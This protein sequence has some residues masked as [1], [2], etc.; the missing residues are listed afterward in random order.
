M[1][2]CAASE[3]AITK[4]YATPLAFES[5]LK[6]Y[7]KDCVRQDGGTVNAVMRGF[8]FQRLTARVFSADPDRWLLKGGQALLVRYPSGARLSS[9]IDFQHLDDDLD[10]ALAA[11]RAAAATDLGDHLSFVPSSSSTHGVQDGGVRQG[12]DV[13][14]GINRR[15]SVSVDLVVRRNITAPPQV[16]SLHP[17]PGVP[18]PTD[19]PKVRL[20]PVVDHI[21]DKVCAMYEWRRDA[22]SSRFR[23]LADIILMTQRETIDAAAAHHA[24]HTEAAHRRSLGRAEL[25]LPQK[26]EMPHESWRSGYA[27]AATDVAGLHGCGTWDAAFTQVD[28]FL[29]PLL[30]TSFVGT[31][32][33]DQQEWRTEGRA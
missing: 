18:W 23:D 28:A 32:H 8:Y 22:P 21:A 11:L 24:L 10:A 19:W 4:S 6:A 33:P 12:F 5:A 26:F 17:R 9:D 16:V 1:C 13:H 20:Y 7:A 31:W 29:T 3:A 2:S 25:R 30:G 14:V 15:A 27:K